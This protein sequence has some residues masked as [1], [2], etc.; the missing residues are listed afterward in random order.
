MAETMF[1]ITQDEL[2]GPEVLRG[3]EVGR[4]VPGVGEVLVRVRAAGVNPADHM[5]RQTGAFGAH[6]PFTL[7]WD[8]SGT[9]SAVGPGVTILAPGDEVFGLLPFPKGAGAYAEYVVAPTRALVPKPDTLTHPE[10]GALP[11]AGLT[12][13]Q[14]LVETA[15]VTSGT[16]VLVTG[17]TGG[18]GHLAIQIAAALGA[19]VTALASTPNVDAARS[20]G[21]ARV[22]DY[23]TTDVATVVAD[24]DV[25]IDVLGGDFTAKA[26]GMV[27][28]G[29]TVVTM[30]PQIA[31]STWTA[32]AERGVRLA[33]LLV[34][35]D[36]LGLLELVRLVEAGRLRPTVSATYPLAE[37]A[38]AHR[39]GGGFGKTVLLP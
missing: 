8:V 17:A 37:A 1:A 27:R 38:A 31:A 3:T 22:V 7:G 14:S 4:P 23:R 2:G 35:A 30:I 16:R 28:P 24:L 32:A 10:A 15:H 19:E 25:V 39:D 33:G 20:Y 5:Y 21:A 34:E 6:P 12:A 26:V 9:V 11:L 29:G 18:V 36:R 13:W